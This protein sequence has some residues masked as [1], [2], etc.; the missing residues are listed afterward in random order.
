MKTF[1][2]RRLVRYGAVAY[3]YGVPV[4]VW[5][6]VIFLLSS[7][8]GLGVSGQYVSLSHFL[9]R[10]GARVAEYFFLGFLSFRFFR[11]CFSGNSH[12]VAAGVI[13]L[14]LPFAL[15][16]E[17]HQLFVTGRQ[18]RIS[19]VFIDAFGVFLALVFCFVLLPL[20]RRRKK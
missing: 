12:A 19:D 2:S 3:L 9:A 14:S 17:A 4:L 20:R 6:S 18:G 13:L 8:S 1:S 10:K 7:Q 11:V 15:S 16:D 5:M